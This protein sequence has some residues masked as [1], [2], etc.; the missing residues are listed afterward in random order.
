MVNSR[1]SSEASSHLSDIIMELHQGLLHLGVYGQCVFLSFRHKVFPGNHS[2]SLVDPCLKLGARTESP[3]W[4]LQL[5]Q[6]LFIMLTFASV[7]VPDL[8]NWTQQ[9]PM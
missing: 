3:C 8:S 4:K 2:E 7:V 1:L 5:V 9:S 6:V